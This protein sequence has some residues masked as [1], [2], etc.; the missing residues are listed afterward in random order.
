MVET[1]LVNDNWKIAVHVVD[2][3]DEQRVT[4]IGIVPRS[5]RE[6]L[7]R[8]LT[9][10]MNPPYSAWNEH[11]AWG[12]SPEDQPEEYL[13]LG[14]TIREEI[15]PK[16]RFNKDRA[17]VLREVE[18]WRRDGIAPVM[19]EPDISRTPVHMRI[20]S[21]R[22]LRSGD[23]DEFFITQDKEAAWELFLR[24]LDLLEPGRF[25]ICFCKGDL[26][27]ATA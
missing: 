1:L 12:Q 15:H 16:C 9:C 21:E 18:K 6:E 5:L 19:K 13:F 3:Y 27:N 11:G 10:Q 20:D 4:R 2:R 22:D 23:V 26:T 24:N 17:E 8:V 14:E 25:G 7:E